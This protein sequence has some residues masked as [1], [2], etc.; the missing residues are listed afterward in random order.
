MK[1]SNLYKI[2]NQE[3]WS[4][5]VIAKDKKN[6]LI[7]IVYHRDIDIAD[8]HVFQREKEKH[9]KKGLEFLIYLQTIAED[10]NISNN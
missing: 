6:S 5:F 8:P 4:N 10:R 1:G 9:Q 2:E 3:V 7:T